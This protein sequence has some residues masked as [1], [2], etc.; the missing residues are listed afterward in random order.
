ML[1]KYLYQVKFTADN[2]KFTADKF[3]FII[4]SSKTSSHYLRINLNALLTIYLFLFYY[5]ELIFILSLTAITSYHQLQ[6]KIFFY[7]QLSTFHKNVIFF[8]KITFSNNRI[9]SNLMIINWTSFSKKILTKTL[10]LFIS[11]NL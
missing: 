8:K 3:T 7:K 5:L 2:K 4:K 6:W 11:I 10:F 9:S 1:W